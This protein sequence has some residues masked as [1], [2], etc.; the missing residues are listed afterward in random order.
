MCGLLNVELEWNPEH[1]S[2][3]TTAR[4]LGCLDHLITIDML[5]KSTSEM[6]SGKAAA[7]PGIVVRI[8]AAGDTGATMLP[9]LF[10]MA[11]FQLTGSKISMSASV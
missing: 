1:L 4:R 11:R 3:E 8:R 10:V 7:P 5:K 2:N 6:N 9:Q